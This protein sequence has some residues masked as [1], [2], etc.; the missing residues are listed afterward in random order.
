MEQAKEKSALVNQMLDS[1][2]KLCQK[3]NLS[4]KLSYNAVIGVTDV[5]EDVVYDQPFADIGF[6]QE[7]KQ[8]LSN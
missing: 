5:A 1:M 2:R 3:L 8:S 6:I 7:I 4:E